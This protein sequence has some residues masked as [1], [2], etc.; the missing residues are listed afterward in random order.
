MGHKEDAAVADRVLHE[1]VDYLMQ[2]GWPT[3]DID[4]QIADR[5]YRRWVKE[6]EEAWAQSG[7]RDRDTLRDALEQTFAEHYGEHGAQARLIMFS[8]VLECRARREGTVHQ[9]RPTA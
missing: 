9:G 3:K 4:E 2:D 5:L 7:Y 8:L 1:A 6:T